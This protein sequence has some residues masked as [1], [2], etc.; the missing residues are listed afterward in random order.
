MP[1]SSSP[2]ATRRRSAPR[3]P[4]CCSTVPGAPSSASAPASGRCG[5]SRSTSCWNASGPRTPSSP[6]RPRRPRTPSRPRSPRRSCA[7]VSERRHSDEEEAAMSAPTTVDQGALLRG[8]ARPRVI[9]PRRTTENAPGPRYD[10]PE[11]RRT[12]A[13]AT[14]AREHDRLCVEAIDP[15]EISAGLEAAGVDDRRARTQYGVASVFD[16]A[17]ELF[18]SVPRRPPA[19]PSP[20][21]PWYRP[22]R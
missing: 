19:E 6:R 12:D 11:R 17:V 15:W 18:V 2:R 22:L 13:L 10:G 4:T 16:L 1:G 7:G 5:P 21:D 3:W 9:A 20:P 14:L 8:L